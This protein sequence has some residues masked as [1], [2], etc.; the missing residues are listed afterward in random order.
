MFFC[1]QWK[2]TNMK[3]KKQEKKHKLSTLDHKNLQRTKENR[4]Y[5]IYVIKFSPRKSLKTEVH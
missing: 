4:F 2:N 1:D 5:Y 3:K